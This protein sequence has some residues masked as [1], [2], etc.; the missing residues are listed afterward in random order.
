MVSLCTSCDI[1]GTESFI[2]YLDLEQCKSKCLDDV[3]CLGIDF[4]KGRRDRQC[5]HNFAQN[6]KFG[7]HSYF[8]AWIKTNVCGILFKNHNYQKV[9]CLNIYITMK[10]IE[11]SNFLSFIRKLI[12]VLRKEKCADV[13]G[14]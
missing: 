4:G 3:T 8:D 5:Y 10:F 6:V 12:N 13:M 11:K 14:W 2:D 7:S 9:F 1:A